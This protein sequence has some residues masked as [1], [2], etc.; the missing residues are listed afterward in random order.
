MFGVHLILVYY[1]ALLLG[2]GLLIRWGIRTTMSFLQAIATRTRAIESL[3]HS[4]DSLSRTI[5][6]P[7]AGD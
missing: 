4:I 1:L 3:S 5:E 2:V 6:S 7:K